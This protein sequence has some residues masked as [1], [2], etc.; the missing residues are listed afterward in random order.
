MTDRPKLIDE[1]Q[2]STVELTDA[3]RLSER[4]KADKKMLLELLAA[5]VVGE[6]A[7]MDKRHYRV[8]YAS[9]GIL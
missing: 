4:V 7:K 5:F 9:T 6:K 3:P 2:K 1:L 8:A